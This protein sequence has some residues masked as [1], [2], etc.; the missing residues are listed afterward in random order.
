MCRQRPI[1]TQHIFDNRL[2]TVL[3]LHRHI[4]ERK[5]LEIQEMLSYKHANLVFYG[6]FVCLHCTM[7]VYFCVNRFV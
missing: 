3:S 2:C 7:S 5:R 1:N 6:P 4:N